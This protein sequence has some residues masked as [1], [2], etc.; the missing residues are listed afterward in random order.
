MHVGKAKYFTQKLSI[1]YK[2]LRRYYFVLMKAF[3]ILKSRFFSHSPFVLLHIITYRCNCKCKICSRWR[4]LSD[5]KN[6]LSV[7]ETFKMLEDAKEA[8]MTNYVVEG[9]EPLL[10]EDIPKIL[11]YAKKLDFDTAIVTNGFYLKDRY[12]EIMP[13]TDSIIVSIDSHD[14][15]HDEMRGANG[16]LDRAVEGIRLCKNYKINVTINCVLCKLNLKKIKGLA[17]FSEELQIPIV[18]QPLDIYK[19]Y[20]EHLRPIQSELQK[21]FSKIKKLKQS[22]YKIRNS[23]HYL[24]HIIENKNYVCHYPKCYVYLMPNGNIVSCCGIIDK[25]WGNIKTTSFNEIFKSKEFRE[26]CKKTEGCNECNSN[27][28]IETSLLYSLNPKYFINF[29]NLIRQ[30]NP[31]WGFKI[32]DSNFIK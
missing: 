30:I 7:E 25:I 18:I 11:E 22:G 5:K 9:G 29:N 4:K 6:E 23:Y 2:Y 15:L 31:N 8:G 20:N 28:V 17:N 16:I 26:L 32:S 21:T 1:K 13:F 3:N 10:I 19:G 24:E 12:K 14:K 27:L